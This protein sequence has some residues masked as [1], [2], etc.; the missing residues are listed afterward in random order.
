METGI[1]VEDDR[2]IDQNRSTW[3]VEVLGRKGVAIGVMSAEH[4]VDV[5]HRVV[6]S[7]Q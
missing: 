5:V 3:I 2:E 6:E 7:S 1:L 4:A